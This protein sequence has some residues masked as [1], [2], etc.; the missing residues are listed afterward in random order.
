MDSGVKRRYESPRRDAQ[1]AQTRQ[2]I[3]EAAR[4]MFEAAG[5]N[6]TSVPAIADEAGVALKTVY[7]AFDSK[8]RLLRA[9]WEARLGAQ[10]ETI[11]VLERAWFR[12]V[13]ATPDP[14]SKLALVA[15]QSRR[16]K[17]RTGSLLEVIRVAAPTDAEIATL[18]EDIESKLLRVQR[19][20]IDQL[21]HSGHLSSAMTAKD[22]AD[23]MWTLNHPDVWQLLVAKRRWTPS[24]YEKWLADAFRLHLLAHSD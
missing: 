6:A 20:V 2:V 8:A 3:I 18:W 16:V 24:R 13:A 4:Q 11:P 10:E 19:A 21:R 17:S 22:A 14:I 15:A 5:Y 1:A 23:V 9:V 7:L 12:E